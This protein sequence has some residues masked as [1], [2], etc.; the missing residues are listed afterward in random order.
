MGRLSSL[1]EEVSRWENLL[2][3]VISLHE[4]AREAEKEGSTE[5]EEE[6]KKR[7]I[8]LEKEF[9]RLEFFILFSEKYDANNAIVAFHAGTGGTEAQD[10][11]AM[12]LR[13]YLR[14]AERHGCKFGSANSKFAEPAGIGKKIH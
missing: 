5:I 12:L 7:F 1:K 4:L 2:S 8:E 10:W 11:A 3:E 9:S 13:M 6:I 14:F